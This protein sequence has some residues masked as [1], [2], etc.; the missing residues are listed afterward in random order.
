MLAGISDF[1][2]ISAR[3]QMPATLWCQDRITMAARLRANRNS[4]RRSDCRDG[5]GQKLVAGM[6]P[7]LKDLGFTILRG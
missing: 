7:G 3:K 6:R 5:A 1:N 4:F 2:F